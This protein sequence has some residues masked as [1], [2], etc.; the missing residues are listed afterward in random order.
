LKIHDCEFPDDLLYDV[1]NDIWLKTLPDW[2]AQ[3]GITTVLSFLS[4]W[5]QRINLKQDLVQV[6]RGQLVATIESARHFSAVRTPVSGKI[7]RFN[8]AIQK[9]PRLINSA[10]YGDGWVVEIETKDVSNNIGLEKASEAYEKLRNRIKEL[11]VQ[12]F[13]KLPD[14]ELVSVGS[15]CSATLANLDELLAKR[16]VGTVVHIVSDDPFAEIEM[17]RWADQRKQ[18]L[19]ET[20]QDENNLFHFLVEKKTASST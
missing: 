18:I 4:G 15:E 1:G 19:L 9:N 20:L 12:C 7:R 5:F 8:P 13:A 3:V 14:E 16:P 17:V 6:T 11:K 2:S 10:P